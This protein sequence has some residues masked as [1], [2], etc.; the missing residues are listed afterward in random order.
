M[1]GVTGTTV[2]VVTTGHGVA[3]GSNRDERFPGGTLAM[4]APYFAAAGVDISSFAAGTLNIDVTPWRLVIDTPAIT[5]RAVAWHP[6]EPA[7]DFSFVSC[8][9]GHDPTDLV[10]G[11][12]YHPHPATKP[13]HHQPPGVIEVLA[14]TIPDVGRGS[15]LHVAVVAGQAHFRLGE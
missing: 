12:V 14:P 13:E 3:S 2:G 9:V 15:V 7:E 1:A 11:L 5:L 10:L 6:T 4:Q 8:A